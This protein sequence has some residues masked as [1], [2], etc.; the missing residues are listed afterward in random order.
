MGNG[1]VYVGNLILIP[2]AILTNVVVIYF[3]VVCTLC[4]DDFF[5]YVISRFPF[6]LSTITFILYTA[7]C[8]LTAFFMFQIFP[9][10]N[11]VLNSFNIV[12]LFFASISVIAFVSNSFVNQSDYK[13]KAFTFV[14]AYPNDMK[15][16]R[17]KLKLNVV[18][19][20]QL[21]PLLHQYI[22][23]RTETPSIIIICFFIPWLV[24]EIILLRTIHKK[25]K[26]QYQTNSNEYESNDTETPLNNLV[27]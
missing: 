6:I 1:F 2:W 15:T 3:F 23:G 10:H 22:T 12:F 4:W 5:P 17:L 24:M 18:D 16:K 8:I 25:L 19:D 21:A 14:V 20:S 11:I 26:Q 13:N 9:N 7:S 27:D